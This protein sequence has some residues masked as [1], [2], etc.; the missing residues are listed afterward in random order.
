MIRIRV[1][2]R[3]RVTYEIITVNDPFIVIS[4]LDYL[5]TLTLTLTITPTL[6][7]TL[8]LTDGFT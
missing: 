5:L 1:R 8:T 7:L 3:E 6:T 2:V 4:I